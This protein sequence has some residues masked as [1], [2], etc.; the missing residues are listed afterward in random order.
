MDNATARWLDRIRT[1]SS[2]V[3]EALANL[4]AEYNEMLEADR[5]FFAT[6]DTVWASPKT[7]SQTAQ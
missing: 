6:Q 2:T 3:E 1:G 5:Q 7:Y 4:S